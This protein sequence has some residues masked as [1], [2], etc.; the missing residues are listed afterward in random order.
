M[1]YFKDEFKYSQSRQARIKEL[2]DLTFTHWRKARGDGNC[3]YR[4]VGVTYIE[5]L[6]RENEV[7]N[8]IK[9]LEDFN[10]N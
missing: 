2:E 3:Y 7:E 1:Q 8:F 9:D 5:A 6:I 4:S 10:E